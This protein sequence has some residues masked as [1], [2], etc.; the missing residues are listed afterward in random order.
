SGDLRE[1][2]RGAGGP[3]RG[4]GGRRPEYLRSD[5][6]GHAGDRHPGGDPRAAGRG[7]RP[8]RGRHRPVHARRRPVL[9]LPPRRGHPDRPLRRGR[10]TAVTT[11]LRPRTTSRSRIAS[12]ST[13]TVSWSGRPPGLRT[14]F[15]HHRRGG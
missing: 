3:A 14:C 11:H 5:L 6:L 2:L 8:R 4:G 13:T 7:R 10:P 1:V 9:L 15:T 12:F